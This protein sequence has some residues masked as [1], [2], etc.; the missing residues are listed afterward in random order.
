MSR[1]FQGGRRSAWKLASKG[2]EEWKKLKGWFKLAEQL[3][4]LPV[5]K[6]RGYPTVH[7]YKLEW[8]GREKNTVFFNFLG[9]FERLGESILTA[10]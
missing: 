5:P 2:K 1:S 8:R 10:L 4:T 7:L 6:N 3:R 9:V